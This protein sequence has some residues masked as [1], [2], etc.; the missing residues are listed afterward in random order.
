MNKALYIQEINEN[1]LSF[2]ID[3]L[4]DISNYVKYLKYQEYIDPTLEIVSNDEWYNKVNKGI[5]EI[6]NNESLNFPSC[7]KCL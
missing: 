6:R 7:H 3:K 2:D 5:K 4:K 1:I